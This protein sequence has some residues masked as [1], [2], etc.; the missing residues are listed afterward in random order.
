MASQAGQMIMIRSDGKRW[1]LTKDS[2]LK[3]KID[4]IADLLREKG[5]FRHA[6]VTKTLVIKEALWRGL[7]QLETECH[8]LSD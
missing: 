5:P 6:R 1:A 8:D 2:D 3:A 7:L 4:E